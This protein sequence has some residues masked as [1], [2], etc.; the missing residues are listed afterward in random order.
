MAHEKLPDWR[1][2]ACGNTSHDFFRVAALVWCVRDSRNRVVPPEK[3]FVSVNETS[4]ILCIA[5][6]PT[7]PGVIYFCE[8]TQ[9]CGHRGPA[10]EFVTAAASN[11][12]GGN[13]D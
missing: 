13:H 9:L 10:S 6:L 8:Q 11:A 4:T 3:T 1:C 7:P 5:E 12:E 2:P